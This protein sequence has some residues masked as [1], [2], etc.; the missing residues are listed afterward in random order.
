MNTNALIA[1]LKE[2]RSKIKYAQTESDKQY[3]G[4]ETYME[5]ALQNIEMAL[6]NL[7]VVFPD[8]KLDG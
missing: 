2:A 6:L 5:K 7:G 1:K 8:Q 4:V 3:L